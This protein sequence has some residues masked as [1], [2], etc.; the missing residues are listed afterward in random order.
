MTCFTTFVGFG[1]KCR[2]GFSIKSIKSCLP[3]LTPFSELR[4]Q[5]SFS[6]WRWLLAVNLD[7][8]RL[9]WCERLMLPLYGALLVK[10]PPIEWDSMPHSRFLRTF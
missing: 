9:C 5:K 1:F 2:S 6:D 4:C 10:W 8:C 7:C 3:L